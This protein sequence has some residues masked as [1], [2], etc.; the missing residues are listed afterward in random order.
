ME[1]KEYKELEQKIKE[2]EQKI[3]ENEKNHKLEINE[4][5]RIYE[6]KINEVKNKYEG[7][8]QELEKNLEI[9]LQDYKIK[10]IKEEEIY[11]IKKNDNVNLLNN[12]KCENIKDLKKINHISGLEVI[13][14]NTIAVYKIK[15]NCEILYEL[16]YCDNTGKNIIIYDIV[17]NKNI[18]IIR[19]AH[20]NYIYQIK[21]Y[22]QSMSKKHILFTSSKDK[23]VKMWDISN[24][25]ITNILIINYSF[26]LYRAPF[27]LMFKN[28]NYF[29]L[30]G[31]SNEKKKIWNQKG[32][33]IG[34]I[35]KSN[36]NNGS[37]IE[38]VYIEN[39]PYI[40]LGGDNFC[41][42]LD[43]EN[44]NIKL[45]KNNNIKDCRHN[46]INLFNK[47]K[48]IY[49]IDGDS[50]GNLSIFDFIST[51]LIKFISLKENIYSLCSLNEKYLLVG[52]YSKM[53]VIDIDNNSV[54]KEYI[55][56][57]G[58]QIDTIKKIIIPEKGEYI[59]SFSI[60]HIG[61]WK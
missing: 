56:G 8:I 38:A 18:N 25:N 10:K 50:D 42:C 49:L 48:N 41:E 45:Y 24:I 21:H 43:Y 28:E 37:F 52:N 11:E 22:Y 31:E 34:P 1:K 57:G 40:I 35:E 53:K 23:S 4:L 2:L 29:I 32:E 16:A 6:E 47:N 36:L 15:R 26:D 13:Y 44:N 12:F 27:C 39:Q 9:L 55:H 60:N 3:N 30:G 33:L 17:L 58:Y 54:V 19:N 61:I 51:N 20:S 46:N 14:W 5:K 59:F 7:K